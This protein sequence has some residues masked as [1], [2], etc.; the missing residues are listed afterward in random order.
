MRNSSFHHGS[1]NS[2]RVKEIL[3]HLESKGEVGATTLELKDALVGTRPSS[4]VSELRACLAGSGRWI[5]TK[6]EGTNANGKRVHRYILHAKPRQSD[7]PAQTP[8]DPPRLFL[9]TTQPAFE[10]A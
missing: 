4:D 10:F 2:P 8:T 6:F 5:E 7:Q 3:A 9:T 1:L